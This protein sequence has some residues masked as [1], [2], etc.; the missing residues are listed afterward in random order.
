[1]KNYS[2]T[3]HNLHPRHRKELEASAIASDLIDLN[4]RSVSGDSAYSELL[5]AL[6]NSERL[7]TGRLAS[8]WLK[9]YQHL[10][11]GGWWVD[12]VY[13]C[14]G[15][16]S[17]WGL[18]KP[19][20]PRISQDGKTIK[21]ES[22]AKTPTEPI[23]LR[24]PIAIAALIAD[25]AGGTLPPDYRPEQFWKIALEQNWTI[26]ITEGAKKAA[27]L[28][29][30][31]YAAIA[32][33]GI[34]N[35]MKPRTPEQKMLG[36]TFPELHEL[37]KPFTTKD[38]EIYFAFDQDLKPQTR[39]QVSHAINRC[40]G[41]FSKAGCTVKVVEWDSNLG[42]GVDDLIANHGIESFEKE[43]KK[44]QLFDQ[45]KAAN[46][47]QLSKPVDHQFNR[48]YIG[49][50]DIPKDAH[51]VALK[52]PKGTGK[53]E[54]ISRYIQEPLRDGKK[55]LLLTHR[56]QLGTEL[57]N[58]LGIDYISEVR[59]S[60]MAGQMGYGLCVDSLHSKSQARFNADNWHGA[61]VIIDE[62]EQVV[63]H[64]LN[65]RTEVSK[66]RREVLDNF[67][68]CLINSIAGGGQIIIADAD[69]CDISIDLISSILSSELSD[70]CNDEQFKP[71]LWIA[72]NTYN[73][74]TYNCYVYPETTPD[75]LIAD[76]LNSI[77]YINADINTDIERV[78][79]NLP[80]HLI[81][82]SAQK[83]KGKYSTQNL[84][85]LVEKRNPELKILRID[86]ET[87]ADKEHNAF[88]C[89][90]FLNQMVSDYDV[91]IVSPTIETGVSLDVECFSKVWGVFQG[92]QTVE[93]VAQML[94]RLRDNVDRYIWV[95]KAG[96]N[97]IGDGSMSPRGLEESNSQ[98]FKSNVRIA[99]IS[100]YSEDDSDRYFTKAL[101]RRGAYINSVRKVYRDTVL[102]KLRD[103]GKNVVLLGESSN[104]D[105]KGTKAELK[106]NRDESYQEHCQEIAT[107]PSISNSQ[108]K[109]LEKQRGLTKPERDKLRRGKL[110]RRYCSD[111]VDPEMVRRDDEGFYK[112]LRF[113]YYLD[114]G[115]DFLAKRD[116]AIIERDIEESGGRPWKFDTNIRMFGTKIATLQY[117]NIEGLMKRREWRK[118][119][120]ELLELEAKAKAARRDIKTILGITINPKDSP[121]AIAQLVLGLLG[122]KLPYLRREG[123]DGARVR[124]YGAATSKFSASTSTNNK[125]DN[126]MDIWG[127]GRSAI[128]DRWRDRDL[129]GLTDEQAA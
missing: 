99:N 95:N 82:L 32:V 76:M 61:I 108:Y 111:K 75:K 67:K 112:N 13:P 71:K 5:Y 53:T 44:A 24:V 63:W 34:W 15:G 64:L 105:M 1:M 129:A 60:E 41:L 118:D 102:D 12:G 37:L 30:A 17:D 23:F 46:Y 92:V 3:H 120:P 124:V 39:K 62:I 80:K 7:N 91:V 78:D 21:Y 89:I 86:A 40:G 103:E 14:T 36:V 98:L 50:L 115:K 22:P 45:F 43:I 51:I 90:P 57:C 127:D 42:K 54:F 100:S 117:L 68:Q 73:A 33:S 38:R 109:E 85:R 48:R 123:K 6:P 79:S 119:D 106:A 26:Y 4:F 58:R 19:D 107:A 52:A 126:S 113:H 9:K 125:G 121:I 49:D 83:A 110:E 47:T 20:R 31:G 97:Q 74:A 72:E 10:D 104:D 29:S 11:H 66:H 84:E 2:T 94:D 114:Q 8:H 88:G 101:T 25:R 59:N 35:T 122:L 96:L 81:C 77:A 55:A 18:L 93:S 70:N 28:L 69:L 116:R 27:S 56:I 16:V 128:F 65:A 87:I